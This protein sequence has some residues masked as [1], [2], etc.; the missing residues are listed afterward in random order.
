MR[1]FPL[2]RLITALFLTILLFPGFLLANDGFVGVQGTQFTLNENPFYYTG[3]NNYYIGIDP[4]I[5]Q[6]QVDEVLTSAKNMGISAVRAW[7][8]NDG[9]GGLQTA[10]GVYDET[11][12]KKLDYAIYKAGQLG[13]KLI[14]P[15]VNNWDDY[16][17]MNQYVS[18]AG[19]SGH[20]SFYTNTTCKTNYKNH[21]NTLLNRANFYSGVAYKDDPTIMS[22][23]LANEPRAG[24]STTLKNWITEMSAYVKGL[25][26]KHLLTTGVEG[27]SISEFRTYHLNMPNIDFATMHI[28]SDYW[29]MD[30]A[31]SKQYIDDRIV[32]AN[33]MLR[34]PVILEEF[35][36]YRDVAKP[37]PA[38]PTGGTGNTSTRDTYFQNFY[39]VVRENHGA[40]SNF[41]IL[42]HNTYPDYDGFGVYSQDVSTTNIIK[43]EAA[44]MSAKNNG[45]RTVPLFDFG[46]STQGWAVDGGMTGSGPLSISQTEAQGFPFPTSNGALQ[47]NGLN[48]AGTG[49]VDAGAVR[50]IP[51]SWGIMNFSGEGIEKF[52]VQ[53]LAPAEYGSGLKASI[54]IHTGSGWAWNE[55]PWITLI[56]G[57]WT[58]I[59]FSTIGFDLTSLRDFGV[60]FALDGGSYNG[61]VYVDFLATE[62]P[63]PLPGS[64][65]LL[66]SGL[67]G[68]M[69]LPRIRRRYHFLR[70]ESCRH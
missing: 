25:D 11:V 29:G 6:A 51:S 32:E 66:G 28:Y 65:V 43:N 58:E 19:T 47:I 59:Y 2:V 23:E 63:V 35:G 27:Q 4:G 24:N 53:V 13:I 30:L 20:D 39:D 18:W 57:E 54:Y 62:S 17:G 26:S 50:F 3:T 22:W 49:W 37:D 44:L 8:F 68:L 45:N 34:M 46:T 33:T 55:G 52:T 70:K 5:T 60:H 61:P 42:Y 10:P 14:I 48:V 41:W 67:L 12:F 1:L 69:A 21:I 31:A 56:P 64:V 16:G 9:S 7:G 36:K 40:G 38:V 15:F